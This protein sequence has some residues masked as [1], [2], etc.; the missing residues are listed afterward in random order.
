VEGHTIVID[1][2]RKGYKN[3]VEIHYSEASY[4]IWFES[5]CSHAIVKPKDKKD[6]PISTFATGAVYPRTRYLLASRKKVYE[7]RF[8][9]K[10]YIP[11]SKLIKRSKRLY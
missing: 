11:F 3:V 9:D 10:N 4:V 7:K 5:K 8:H 1:Y 2:E 6:I